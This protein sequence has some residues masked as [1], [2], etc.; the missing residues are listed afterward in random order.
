MQPI[1]FKGHNIVFGENQP[2]YK[3]LPAF[4]DNDGNVVT[5]WKLTFYERLKILFSGRFYL[6]TLTFKSPI[7]PMLPMVENPL[8]F[9]N[10]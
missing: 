6:Q 1:K 3:P 2:Q 5:C 4:I 7:Q 10:P 9:D 8:K